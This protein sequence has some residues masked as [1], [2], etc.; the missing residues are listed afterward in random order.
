MDMP[1]DLDA[2]I[3]LL[4]PTDENTFFTIDDVESGKAF[5]IIA[6]V[7]IGQDLNQSV[8]SFDLRVG[9]IN[10]T[11]STSVVTV[12]DNGPLTPASAPHLDERR[13]NVP[14]GWTASPGDVLQAVASYKVTAGV[15][16]DYSTAQSVT[17]VVS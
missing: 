9:I 1:S 17:F 12:Q 2:S 16:I 3:K 6:N 5:D 4:Y 8:D 11:Q 15:N 14:A 13:V 7:E 10:L